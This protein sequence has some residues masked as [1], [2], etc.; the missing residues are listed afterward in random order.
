MEQQMRKETIWI[1]AHPD[2][3]RFYTQPKPVTASRGAILRK[4]GYMIF[5]TE[6]TFPPAFSASAQVVENSGMTEQWERDDAPDANDTGTGE[7]G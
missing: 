3:D 2:E 6:V 7:A 5:K 4:Q 1:I